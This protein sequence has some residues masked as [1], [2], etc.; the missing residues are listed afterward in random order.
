MPALARFPLR[1]PLQFRI[2]ADF[3][4]S[5][6]CELWFNYRHSVT[7]LQCCRGVGC[8]R[9]VQCAA[10]GPDPSPKAVS[11]TVL[12]FSSKLK[13]KKKSGKLRNSCART[14]SPALAGQSMAALPKQ[15]ACSPRVLNS[16]FSSIHPDSR[17]LSCAG[18]KQSHVQRRLADPRRQ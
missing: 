14:Q 15:A 7:I 12:L 13:R 4:P 6:G 8:Y 10:V 5:A 11:N 16:E 18:H 1:P 17:S 9:V 2:F 3:R